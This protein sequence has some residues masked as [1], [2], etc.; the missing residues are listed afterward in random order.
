MVTFGGTA[1]AHHLAAPPHG[2]PLE[3]GL[4]GERFVVAVG[5]EPVEQV[6]DLFRRR[7]VCAPG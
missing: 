6:P 5:R 7:T 2:L 1:A 4:D 3:P